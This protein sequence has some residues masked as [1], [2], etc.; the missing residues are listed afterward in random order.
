MRDHGLHGIS[1]VRDATHR[2][3]GQTG[4]ETLPVIHRSKVR[5]SLLVILCAARQVTAKVARHPE[6]IKSFRDTGLITHFLK[7]AQGFLVTCERFNW[8][9]D[10]E[11]PIPH[12]I[13]AVGRNGGILERRGEIE[14]LLVIL[15]AALVI[16]SSP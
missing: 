12:A 10:I 4:R 7:D 8:T 14:G 11:V 3:S 16:T 15:A 2:Q 5:D 1:L 13:E 9:F 6:Q